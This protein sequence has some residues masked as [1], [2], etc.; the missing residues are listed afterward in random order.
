MIFD[1]ACG[2]VERHFPELRK[3][4]ENAKLFYFPGRAHELLPT[5]MDNA[6]F[7]AENFFLPFRTVGVEDTASLVV[8]HDI[9]PNA[10]G[11]YVEREFMEF[12]PLDNLESEEFREGKAPVELMY[13][14]YSLE[15][16]ERQRGKICIFK[17]KICYTYFS[18]TKHMLG[19]GIEEILVADKA[20]VTAR[21]R[22]P[23]ADFLGS[24]KLLANIST[25]IEEII[26]FN[27]PDRFIVE[28][29]PA[30]VKHRGG[31]SLRILRSVERPQYILLKPQEIRQRLHL[32]GV[33]SGYGSTKTPHERRRHYRTLKSDK[34]VNKK[35]ETVVVKGTWVGPSEA[36]VEGR[37]YKVLFDR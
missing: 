19:G 17:G 30:K 27:S 36:V 24:Q 15:E 1:K 6:E 13:E 14:L 21:F 31:R 10:R 25:A 34:F 16:I 28:S 29:R 18:S 26:Y 22:I 3:Y 5:R 2:I 37:V 12:L 4:M 35:G 7:I 23:I 32:P 8:L 9:D 11:T 20:R 33:G